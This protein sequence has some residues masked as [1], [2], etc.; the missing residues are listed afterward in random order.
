MNTIKFAPYNEFVTE[1]H[2]VERGYLKR[3]EMGD[4]SGK[5]YQPCNLD[6]LVI[7][8]CQNHCFFCIKKN[9]HGDITQSTF[10]ESLETAVTRL[11][12]KGIEL[13]ATITGGEPTLRVYNCKQNFS[14]ILPE[15]I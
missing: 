15:I 7:N 8:A 6:V 13:E 12:E 3:L 2:Q 5:V 1:Q 14:Q 4:F 9:Y 10:L 11:I